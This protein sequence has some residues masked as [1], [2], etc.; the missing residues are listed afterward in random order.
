MGIPC[1]ALLATGAFICL[2]GCAVGP[3]YEPP[4]I[5]VPT[6]FGAASPRPPVASTSADMDPIRWWQVLNDA[7]LN[8]LIQRAI[9]S[10]PDI[11]I[12]LTRVQEARSQEIVELGAM[13]P[14]A[15]GSGTVATGSGTDLTRGRVAPSIR[16]G[17]V[18]TDVKSISRMGGFDAVWELDLIGKHRRSLEAAHDDTEAQ[19]ELRSAALITVIADVAR[20]YF[21]IRGQQMQQEI[22]LR[23]VA[24]T[25]RTVGL[26]KTRSSGHEQS[27]SSESSSSAAA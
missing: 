5:P 27:K 12:M 2:S 7:Q 9:A 18:T 11:E 4:A 16:A 8:A 22:V 19:M 20:E 24:T 13:L 21:E 3:D 10:S 25:Q 17:G 23:N 14:T 26:L 6:A 15:G 1:R